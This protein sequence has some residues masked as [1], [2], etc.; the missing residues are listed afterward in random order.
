[1][2]KEERQGQS[3]CVCRLCERERGKY[4]VSVCR[5]GERKKESDRVGGCVCMIWKGRDR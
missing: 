5:L 3:G 4:R 2:R 1:M